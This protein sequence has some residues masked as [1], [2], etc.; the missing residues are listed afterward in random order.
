MF[1]YNDVLVVNT[2][3]RLYMG[4]SF[5]ETS[6]TDMTL[7]AHTCY[8]KKT[9]DPVMG[10]EEDGEGYLMLQEDGLASTSRR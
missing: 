2:G 10:L 9:E 5:A 1:S 3:D 6:E 7:Y 8:A 4:V